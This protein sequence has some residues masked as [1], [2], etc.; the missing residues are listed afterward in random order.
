MVCES[1]IHHDGVRKT[2]DSCE[3]GYDTQVAKLRKENLTM[4]DD[5]FGVGRHAATGHKKAKAACWK[6]GKARI[7]RH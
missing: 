3:T 4:L 6:Q 2:R 1:G 5:A 7:K